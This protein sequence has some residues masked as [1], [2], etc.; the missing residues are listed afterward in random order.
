MS[1]LVFTPAC[2]FAT[3]EPRVVDVVSPAVRQADDAGH[4]VVG[5]LDRR[6]D[7]ADAAGDARR[8]AVA[9]GRCASA[10]CARDLQRA[11]IAALHQRRQV[12]HERVAAA[13]VA[14][15]DQQQLAGA[16]APCARAAAARSSTIARRRELDHAALGVDHLAQARLRAGRDRCR[17][18]PPAR[19]ASVRPS[20]SA[21]EAVA[22][23]A[24]A[25]QHVDD[26]LRTDRAVDLRRP[27]RR[28]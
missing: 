10:S 14:P 23:R 2:A 9:P 18:P 8:A 28:R 22:V 6:D 13:Q 11:A 17:A 7:A 26:A 4:E 5:D 16:L 12:V 25:Q 24:D 21:A 3:R 20:G 19:A 1:T 15:A 27:P